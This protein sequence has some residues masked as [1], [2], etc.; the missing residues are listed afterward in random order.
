MNERNFT[1]GKIFGPL[2]RFTGPVILAL[3]LQTMYGAIDLMIVGKFATSADVSGVSTG[4]QIMMTF[5][6]VAASFS[7]GATILLGQQIGMGKGKEAGKTIGAGIVL[8]AGIAIFLSLFLVILASPI[9]ELMNAP[10]EAFDKTVQYVRI[11]GAGT[12]V[13]VAYNLIGSIFRGIGDSTTPLI[14]VAIASVVNVI[15]DLALVAGFDMGAAGA[16]L[17]T[18]GAQLISVL[19]S[20]MFISKRQLPFDFHKSDIQTNTSIMKRITSIG[21]PIAIQDF[22]VGLSFM[23]ILAIVNNLGLTVS[24]GIGVAEKVCAFI[25]LVPMA[26]SQ[27]TSAFTSQNVGALQ[28]DRAR[29]GLRYAISTSLAFGVVLAWLAFF[30][31]SMLT[32]FFTNDAPVME[33]AAEYLKAYAIDTILV[34]LL[35]CY[36]GYFNGFGLTKFVMIQGIIGAFLVRIPV[37]Y[38]MAGIEPVSLFR[39]GLATPASSFVQ[40]LLCFGCSVYVNR[41]VIPDMLKGN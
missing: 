21:A 23:V 41:K 33:A 19:L 6:S 2:M 35:F 37:S 10:V 25:M 29:T 17:A 13:I 12:F 39:I 26:F 9:S 24:A 31:G 11:C 8:F 36:I 18:V 22:L 4:S 27:S 28:F 1:T 7:T 30:H 14:T 15:G 3:L 38:I 34:S 40:I 16:A 5:T 20:L 32:G